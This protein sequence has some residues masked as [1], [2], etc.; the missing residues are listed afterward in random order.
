MNN[1]LEAT[2][3]STKPDQKKMAERNRTAHAKPA[4][5]ESQARQQKAR[6]Q[7]E[8]ITPELE[9]RGGLDPTRFGDWE[10]NGRAVDF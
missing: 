2:P 6:P 8:K 4:L 1:K 3:A 10:V 9:G 5:A 7:S